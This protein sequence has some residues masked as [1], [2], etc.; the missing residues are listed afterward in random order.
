[1]SS[2]FTVAAVPA[3]MLDWTGSV[4]VVI[5]LV[6]L[7]RKRLAYWHWSNLSLLPYFMLFLSNKQFMM[8]GLQVSYLIFG[9]HGIAL[10]VL[11]HK[12][13]QHQQQFNETFWLMLGWVLVA[14]IFLYSVRTTTFIDKWS[15]VQF[16]IVCT[17][18]IA[19]LATTRKKPWSWLLWMA[20]NVGQAV[21]FWHLGLYAQFGLQFVLFAMSAYGFGQWRADYANQAERADR[22]GE[23]PRPETPQ[24]EAVGN[25]YG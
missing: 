20:I 8:A 12:R 25:V 21:Y 17:S 14:A 24:P 19:N 6:F 2:V 11:Q 16:G 5:S 13:E 10:W 3:W 15:Y 23:T 4:C 18:L 9:I 7:F 1:M 22:G